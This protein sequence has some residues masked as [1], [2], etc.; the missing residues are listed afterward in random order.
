LPTKNILVAR[1]QQ[2]FDEQQQQIIWSILF[3]VLKYL[4]A[5]TKSDMM[6]RVSRPLPSKSRFP[7]ILRAPNCITFSLNVTMPRMQWKQ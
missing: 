5:L 2:I 1:H 7:P 3:H 4:V 6:L